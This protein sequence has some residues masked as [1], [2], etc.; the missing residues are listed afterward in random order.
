MIRKSN[1]LNDF[2]ILKFRKHSEYEGARTH[3]HIL[4]D[5]VINLSFFVRDVKHQDIVE[6]NF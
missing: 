2:N 5:C 6:K 1:K 4:T 3:T